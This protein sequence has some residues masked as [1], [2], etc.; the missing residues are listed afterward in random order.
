MALNTHTTTQEYAPDTVIC[1]LLGGTKYSMTDI[2]LIYYLNFVTILHNL[3]I[4][5][6]L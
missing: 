3:S 6:L 5:S 1:A 2:W 4:T